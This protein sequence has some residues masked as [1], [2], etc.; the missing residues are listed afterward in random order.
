MV[1]L[2]II[3]PDQHTANAIIDHLL[4][5][6]YV[7]EAILVENVF[8]KRLINEQEI[9]TENGYLI[10]ALAKA[11][12]FKEIN[13]YIKTKFKDADVIVY[14][15]PIVDMDLNAQHALIHNTRTI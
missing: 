11:L 15:I 12:L 14:S 13:D 6:K 4:N 10:K 8:R 9:K 7:L 1:N 5:Q 3:T 2:Q